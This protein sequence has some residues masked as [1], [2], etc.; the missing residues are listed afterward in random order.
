M[1]KE[2]TLDDCIQFGR[3]EFIAF[4]RDKR[5]LSDYGIHGNNL[6]IILF[7]VLVCGKQK[8]EDKE[9]QVKFFH[10][11]PGIYDGDSDICFGDFTYDAANVVSEVPLSLEL[12]SFYNHYHLK[13]ESKEFDE[14]KRLLQKYG[15]Y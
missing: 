3:H 11:S 10:K 14:A 7:G 8:P 12:C 4:V 6:G 9:P 13:A 15:L 5:S 2:K 1:V